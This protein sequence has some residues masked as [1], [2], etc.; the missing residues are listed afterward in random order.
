MSSVRS[1]APAHNAGACTTND[2]VDE[3]V[4][5]EDQWSTRERSSR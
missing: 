5:E 4:F 3:V 2:S 1:L